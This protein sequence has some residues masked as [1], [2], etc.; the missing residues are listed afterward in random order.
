M[1]YVL[2]HEINSTLI[3]EL[4]IIKRNSIHSITL[5]TQMMFHENDEKYNFEKSIFDNWSLT[6]SAIIF[7][8]IYITRFY[9]QNRIYLLF[10]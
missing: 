2:I 7:H 1:T 9:I 5:V 6:V 4:S 10:G 3:Y 8:L